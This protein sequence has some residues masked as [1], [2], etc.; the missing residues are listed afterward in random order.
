MQRFVLIFIVF[1]ARTM[2]YFA[3]VALVCFFEMK[4][5]SPRQLWTCL[6]RLPCTWI[7]FFLF[8]A[9]RPFQRENQE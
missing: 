6:I 4:T 1:G 7:F 9:H 2:K 5:F 3:L 8:N